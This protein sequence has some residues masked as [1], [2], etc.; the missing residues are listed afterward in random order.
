[1]KLTL[2]VPIKTAAHGILEY[3]FIVFQRILDV[4]FHVNP[5]LG[6]EFI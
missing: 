4:M 6:K 1:M 5:L 3:F 2:K